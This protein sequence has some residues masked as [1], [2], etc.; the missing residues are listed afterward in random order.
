MMIELIYLNF[1]RLVYS[2][3]EDYNIL[4]NV[5]Q[6]LIKRGLSK[7]GQVQNI[8]FIFIFPFVGFS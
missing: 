5:D 2:Q 8:N 1:G 6:Q 3:L 7:I 4:L